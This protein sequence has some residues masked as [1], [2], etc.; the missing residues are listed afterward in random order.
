MGDMISNP[1]EMASIFSDQ[2]ESAFSDPA[3]I[4]LDM[5]TFPTH[6]LSD[7]QFTVENIINTIDEV[8]GPLLLGLTVSQPF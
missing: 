2:Y 1:A 8:A 5:G 3:T 7:I 6:F 4:Y